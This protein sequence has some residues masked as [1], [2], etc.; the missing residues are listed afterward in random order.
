VQAALH[1]TPMVVVYRV[2]ALTYRLGRRFVKLD[3]FAM[4][5]LIAGQRI[6]PELIQ[7]AFTPE[8]VADEAVS[9]LTDASRAE[10]I[11]E[12]LACVRSRLGGPG[13]SRRAAEAI[14]KVATRTIL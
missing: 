10:H 13:A 3:T 1:G 6:V 14:L 8:A 2:S 12:R 5:N 11:R 7:D 4:V 9:I